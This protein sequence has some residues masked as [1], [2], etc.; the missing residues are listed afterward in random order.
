MRNTLAIA[1]REI[2]FY[3]VS[4]IVYVVTAAF[5]GLISVF[6]A[7]YISDPR[8]VAGTMQYLLGPMNT[9]LLFMIPMLQLSLPSRRSDL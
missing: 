1:G 6:F 3:F 5:L 4:P 2:Q 8:G 7:W 9:L